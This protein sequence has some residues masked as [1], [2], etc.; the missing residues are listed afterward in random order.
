MRSM[1]ILLLHPEER[2]DSHYWRVSGARF[3]H[4]TE[5]LE[6][7]TGDTLRAGVLNGMLGS[8]TVK[9]IDHAA[10]QL[11]VSFR[12]EDEPPAPLPLKLILALPRPKMLKRVLIDASSLGIKQIVLLNSWK[13][14]K[15]Y[16]QTPH[17]NADLLREKLILGLEQ[18]MDTTLPELILAPRFKPFV[19]DE[20]SL[21]SSG[22]KKIVAH[23]GE[24]PQMPHDISEPVTLA[25]GP[26][27][28]WTE[29]EKEMFESQGFECRALGQRILRVETALPTL[30]GRIMRLI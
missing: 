30:V 20:L 15:S 27:G 19:E 23:P 8:A 10:Q 12:A 3:R 26:E 29:Y 7:G 24:Y 21:F 4:I 16:W 2:V 22:S 5:L 14:D 1:N 25:V 28:G 11:L 17:L 6:R 9:E 13:V 18:A